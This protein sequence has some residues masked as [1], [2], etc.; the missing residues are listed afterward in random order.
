M[1]GGWIAAGRRGGRETGPLHFLGPERQG[2]LLW[3]F[4]RALV[5]FAYDDGVTAI[6]KVPL[7]KSSYWI[8]LNNVSPAFRSER[9]MN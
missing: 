5:A 7:V 4:N 3:G 8:T 1:A 2:R 9:M 6:D